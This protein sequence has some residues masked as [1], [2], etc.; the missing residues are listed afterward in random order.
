MSSPLAVVQ[1]N[2][3]VDNLFVFLNAMQSLPENVQL[4]GASLESV[5]QF[6]QQ[7][8][9]LPEQLAR[10]PEQI[11]QAQQQL[12]QVAQAQGGDQVV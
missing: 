1:K 12:M 5:P 11:Q 7:A 8:L 4:L 10:T 9:G 3:D 6:L 2:E